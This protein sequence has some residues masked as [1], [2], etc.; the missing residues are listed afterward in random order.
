MPRKTVTHKHT[1]IEKYNIDDLPAP[2]KDFLGEVENDLTTGMVRGLGRIFFAQ[3]IRNRYLGKV[4][5]NVIFWDKNF[6]N[7]RILG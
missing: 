4:E 1:H 5:K 3:N 6:L 7:F 2:A